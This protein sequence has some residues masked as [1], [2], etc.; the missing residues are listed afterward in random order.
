MLDSSERF[1]ARKLVPFDQV[2]VV[3]RPDLR[4]P[5]QDLFL[6]RKEE[7]GFDR[8]TRAL[9][10][11]GGSEYRRGLALKRGDIGH[12]RQHVKRSM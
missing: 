2:R 6:S 9:D 10:A 5:A 1:E 4:I 12:S 8:T 11:A 7:G 3:D